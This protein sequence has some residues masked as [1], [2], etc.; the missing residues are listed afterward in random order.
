MITLLSRK[1]TSSLALAIALATG[2]GVVTTA[3]FPTEASAQRRDR[4]RDRDNKEEEE[5]DGGGYSTE[6]REAYVPLDELLKSENPDLTGLSAKLVSLASLLNTNDEKFA[7]GNLIFNGAIRLQEPPLQ[8]RGME[9]MI[10]SGNLPPENIGRFN[11]IGYQLANQLGEFPKSRTFLQAAIDNNFTTSDITASSL[12]VAMMES[13]FA[14]GEYDAGFTYLRD[15]IQTQKAQG[16]AVDETWYRRGLTVAYENEI[17]PTVY[18]IATMWL[19]DYP[20]ETNW[21][22]AINIARNLN[23]FQPA[24]ILDLFRLSRSAGALADAADYDYYVE[25]ADARR[26]PSEVKGVIEEGQAAGVVVDSNL[27]LSEALSMAN[28]RIAADRADLPALERDAMSGSAGLRTVVAAGDAFLSYGEFAKA[29]Q[30]YQRSLTMPGVDTNEEL[31][32]LAI[33]Q[34]GLGDYGA[35]RQSLSQVSG[36][37]API[38]MLWTAF[39]NQQE[40]RSGAAPTVMPA[41]A[42]ATAGTSE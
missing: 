17:S 24:E 34:V 33:A 29:A 14:G 25:V 6:F 3:V 2:G 27:Y 4:D 10:E 26:L 22:D 39:A 19:S 32:R 20:S 7:G 38:A 23:D 37:R 1:R 15:A 8:L 28:S 5:N 12:R 30:F 9:L 41:A 31:M 16:L 40:A 13:F 18:Q 42:P 11:F 21:R 36:A 35:A